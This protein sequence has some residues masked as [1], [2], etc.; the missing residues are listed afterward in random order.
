MRG[1][2]RFRIAF[3][4]QGFDALDDYDCREWLLLNGA[5]PQSVNSAFIRALYDL[6]FA[7]EGGDPNRPAIAAGSA[8]RGAFRAFFSYRGAF[9]WKMNGGMGDVVF[10]PLYEVL[11]RRGVQFSFFHRLTSVELAEAATHVERLSFE[12]QAALETGAEYQPLVD[13]HGLPCWPSEP[14]YTQ[15]VGGERLSGANVAWESHHP[16]QGGFE[17]QLKGWAGFRLRGFGGWFGYHRPDLRR[18]RSPKRT[19]ASDA[20]PREVG[21]NPSLSSVVTP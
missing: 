18:H 15:L 2:V 10:A 5:S 6:A 16:V 3:H 8:I 7:Y 21:A 19:L 14:D 17:K 9:F 4:P 11:K 13:V 20:R 1:V 12:V